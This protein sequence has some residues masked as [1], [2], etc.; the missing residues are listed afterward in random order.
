[1]RARALGYG[2]CLVGK[3]GA[4]GGRKV[5]R[6]AE[7]NLGIKIKDVSIGRRFAQAFFVHDGLEMLSILL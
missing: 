7:R 1:M 4:E 6:C 5:S 3:V 2:C